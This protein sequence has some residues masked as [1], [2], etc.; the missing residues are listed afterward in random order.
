MS[1][2]ALEIRTLT[3]FSAVLAS[4]VAFGMSGLAL[5][6]PPE[7]EA[8]SAE[9]EK[10][11][12]ADPSRPMGPPDA[13]NRGTPQGSMYGYLSAAR[14]GDY[15]T[16]GEFLDLRALPPDERDRGPELARKLKVVLD[17][18][19]WVDVVNL[20]DSNA[21][22]ANDGL[23]AWQDRIGDIETAEGVVPILLQRV[24][25]RDDGVRI[26]KVAATTVERI[27]ELYGEFE[28]VWL[29]EWLP[30]VFSEG[31]FLGV[32]LWKWLTLLATLLGASLAALLLAGATTQLAGFLLTRGHRAFDARIVH[33]VRGP[34]RLALT[35]MLF[36][37]GHRS[38]GLSLGFV[39]LLRYLERLLLVVAAAWLTFRLIDLAAVALRIRAE[40]RESVGV[41]PILI[42]GARFAK[43]VIVVIGILGVLGTMGVNV[44][45]AVAGL[46]VGGIAV[47]L[48]AQ[49]TIE[50]LFGG[51][52]LFADRPV[53]VGDFCRY[54]DKMGTVEEIGLR[55]TRVRT[56]DRT[57]VSVPNSEFANRE[58]ENYARRDRMR[59]HTTIGLRY[60]TTPDQL[61][62]VLAQLRQILLAHPRV[63]EEPARVRFVGFGASSLDVD[64]FA[65][66]DTCDGN[67]FLAIREH[68][69][70]LFMRAIEEAGT[71]F[72]FPSSTTYVSQDEGLDE[73]QVRAAE[74]RVAAWRAKGELPFPNFPED[75][76]EEVWN[77]L[78][79]PPPGSPD[80]KRA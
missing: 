67:E 69:Y 15:A 72:A 53:R 32:A 35:V 73:E 59:L 1:F 57:V 61:S 44:S 78:E 20:S 49:K 17:Q 80:A 60:E 34:V 43:I 48:A 38:M 31:E 71:G 4:V 40:Q 27:P 28:P 13:F 55:S 64:V 6:E 51:I 39:D 36:G 74:E 54:G 63:T 65:Y 47:A 66:V 52:T 7:S 50:N 41:V 58:L 76:R 8:S 19:I 33:L 24:P 25:R 42:P 77:S 2:E 37:A 62:Y 56:L 79:W 16:A 29:E 10:P 21:G 46:G 5:A 75:V 18:T 12:P 11:A 14:K 23:P 26:W 45:A 70:L 30:P 68:V 9:A 3:R 22:A